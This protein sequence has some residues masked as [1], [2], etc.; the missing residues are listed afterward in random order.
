MIIST[1]FDINQF[2]LESDN[3]LSLIKTVFI[4]SKVLA[5]YPNNGL[6]FADSSKNI[7]YLYG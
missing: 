7:I 6:I 2:K 3:S 1:K 4:S 5:K